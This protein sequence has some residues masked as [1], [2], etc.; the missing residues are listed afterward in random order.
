MKSEPERIK[1]K[2]AAERHLSARHGQRVCNLPHGDAVV[3]QS[4]GQSEGVQGQSQDGTGV[5]PQR[6]LAQR[7]DADKESNTSIF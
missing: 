3:P 4:V 5:V 1:I 6:G 7:T 2:V